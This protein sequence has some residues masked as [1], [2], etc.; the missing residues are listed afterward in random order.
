MTDAMFIYKTPSF[1]FADSAKTALD[2]EGIECHVLQSM[3]PL[4]GMGIMSHSGEWS[5][6][7]ADPKDFKRAK[8]I[9]ISIG[10]DDAAPVRLPGKLATDVLILLSLLALFLALVISDSN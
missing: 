1:D 5:V 7:V 6:Y 10:A 3:E 9:L 8:E 4:G 2:Q